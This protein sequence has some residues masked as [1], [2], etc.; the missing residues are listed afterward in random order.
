MEE[1]QPYT[2]GEAA[3]DIEAITS[4]WR[5]RVGREFSREI[6]S[7]T[8][9][10]LTWAE[11]DTTWLFTLSIRKGLKEWVAVKETILLPS[12]DDE[13]PNAIIASAIMIAGLNLLHSM[14]KEVFGD[15][16]DYT[17]D[18]N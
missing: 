14:K 12:P 15:V 5:L 3:G 16:E 13:D 2:I 8:G 4:Q 6:E 11:T 9:V 17:D 18:E 1:T 7:V 10:S